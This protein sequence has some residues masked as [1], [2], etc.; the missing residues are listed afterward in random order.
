MALTQRQQVK[1]SVHKHTR[2][3]K[4]CLWM[5]VSPSWRW[6]LPLHHWTTSTG[7]NSLLLRAHTRIRRKTSAVRNRLKSMVHIFSTASSRDGCQSDKNQSISSKTF[8]ITKCKNVPPDF[9]FSPR[10]KSPPTFLMFNSSRELNALLLHYESHDHN[11]N[12]ISLLSYS[13]SK[14]TWS[15]TW[16]DLSKLGAHFV[17][18]GFAYDF[19]NHFLLQ[20]VLGMRRK[21]RKATLWH[22]GRSPGVR[23]VETEHNGRRNAN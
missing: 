21:C 23:R 9:W 4:S 17:Y 1:Q 22:F 10:T 18:L 19:E 15:W 8:Y 5:R 20:A 14:F 16:S 3:E 12:I 6:H 11:I 7:G 13:V 2:G